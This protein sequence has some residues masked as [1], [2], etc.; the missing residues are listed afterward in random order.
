MVGTARKEKGERE[1]SNPT[2]VRQ[3]TFTPGRAHTKE[4]TQTKFFPMFSRNLCWSVHLPLRRK[5][6]LPRSP[7]VSTSSLCTADDVRPS[8]FFFRRY[9]A[10]G[11]L[12]V[13]VL[14]V[15]GVSA[16]LC[17]K[18]LKELLPS[19]SATE[20]A[21]GTASASRRLATG[22]SKRSVSVS[23]GPRGQRCPL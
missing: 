6:R 11:R 21:T 1:V 17:Q 10:V 22:A 12:S 7:C 13:P 19:V 20:A 8:L 16:R 15:L 3:N 5:K 4:L 23:Q 14:F 9:F 18:F 2:A